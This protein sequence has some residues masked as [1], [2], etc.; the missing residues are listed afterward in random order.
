[1]CRRES[2]CL[3]YSIAYLMALVETIDFFRYFNLNPAKLKSLLH[4]FF[5]NSCLNIDV[6]DKDGIR[7]TPREWFVAPYQTI[8]QAIY[9][10][11]NGEIVNYKYDSIKK[12]IVNR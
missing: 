7:Y 6:F 4:N 11:L 5:S 1:M 12:E 8:Y 10:I 9:F 2:R 3:Y